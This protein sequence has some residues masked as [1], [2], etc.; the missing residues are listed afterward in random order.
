MASVTK[1]AARKKKVRQIPSKTKIGEAVKAILQGRKKVESQ[2][3]LTALVIKKLRKENRI[4]SVSPIRMK[5]VALLI[6][7]IE[8]R[9]KTRRTH[10][11]Q[12]VSACPVCEN[13]I[14]PLSMKNL[15]NKK[16]VVGY[17]CGNCG[18]QSDLEVFVPMKYSFV[19]KP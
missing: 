4:F 17:K 12:K 6:P 14:V 19:W 11:L 3:E 2:E 18:Y 5:R 13:E 8:I 16:I 10:K 15:L 7:E 1:V 9:A